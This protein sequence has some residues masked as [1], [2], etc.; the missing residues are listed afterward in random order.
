MIEE[1]GGEQNVTEMMCKC[2]EEKEAV[3]N[4]EEAKMDE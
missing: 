1:M 3:E 4:N 2:E